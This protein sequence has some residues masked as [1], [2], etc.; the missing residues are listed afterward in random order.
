MGSRSKGLQWAL[1]VAVLWI[2]A[3]LVSRSLAHAATESL[4]VWLGSAVTFSALMLAQRQH[5]VPILLGAAIAATVWGWWAHALGVPAAIVF[6]AVEPLSMAAGAWVALMGAGMTVDQR[7]GAMSTLAGAGGIIAGAWVASGV[8][9]SLVL[10]LWHWQRPSADLAAEWVA[11]FCST[12]LGIL[13]L[14]PLA[15]AFQGFRVRRSGGLPMPQFLGGAL[16]FA[17]FVIVALAVFSGGVEQRLG[18]QASTLTYLP[19]PFLLLAVLLWGPRGGALAMLVGAMLV[20]GLTARGGGPFAIHERF[21]GEAV[22]GAQAF[23][24]VWA[25]VVLLAS[26][27]SEGRRAALRTA[28][29]WQLR[30]ERTLEAAG[31]ATVE[32]DAVTGRALWGEGATRVL[33]AAATDAA[34]RDEWL[35]GIDAS[36][37]GLVQAAWDAV[38]E[39]RVAS[40]E[41]EYVVHARDGRRL[42]VHEQLAGVRGGDG[43]VET[44]AALIRTDAPEQGLG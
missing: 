6:G 28:R 17:A 37:R 1:A 31:V 23:V 35:D 41:H 44:V 20:I 32:Y 14:V 43:T 15:C 4:P 9:A 27:L 38:A 21:A 22:I 29:E 2:G 25:I 5:R 39:G 30:Y 7:D 8:G 11:W 33:G 34:T 10:G 24:A 16:A 40:T 3:G 12:G 13:L 26:A 42:R 36:E 18:D 19:M